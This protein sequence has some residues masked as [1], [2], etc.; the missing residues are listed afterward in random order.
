MDF[1][2][3]CRG[4]TD[5][6]KTEKWCLRS[7]IC[8]GCASIKTII[9]RKRVSRDPFEEPEMQILK[10]KKERRVVRENAA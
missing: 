9:K 7:T 4:G 10:R 2:K 3:E 6:K 8:F 5:Q 1:G